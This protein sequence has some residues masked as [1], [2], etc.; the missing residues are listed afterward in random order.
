MEH[1]HA[2]AINYPA[3]IE[4]ALL[5]LT[6]VMLLSKAMQGVLEYY[7]HPRYTPLV[8][9]CGLVLLLAAGARMR[10]IYSGREPIG[11][12]WRAYAL[13]CV[14]LVLGTVVPARPLGAG[15]LQGLAAN[16]AA[17]GA[18]P[19]TDDSARWNLLEWATAISTRPGLEG[20]PVDVVGFVYH[21]EGG[22]GAFTVARYVVTCCT[23]DGSG[24][25]LPVQ[26]ASTPP[27]GAWVRVNGSFGQIDTGETLVPGILASAVNVVPQP[28]NPY[29]Y[30]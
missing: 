17:L 1:N 3:L 11:T 14:P 29:L 28:E 19:T 25:G 7:I 10:G 4:T 20:R 2:R 8:M 5:A 9:L 24:V 13:L 26:W 6:G 12:R 21:P 15:S 23:A 18:G 22:A 27:D 30:P 16:P